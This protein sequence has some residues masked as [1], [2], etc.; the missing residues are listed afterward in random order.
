MSKQRCLQSQQCSLQGPSPAGRQARERPGSATHG[1]TADRSQG[2]CGAIA[3]GSS[4]PGHSQ[5]R[6]E[7][8]KRTRAEAKDGAGEAQVRVELQRRERQVG[9]RMP[10]RRCR[11]QKA[12]LHGGLGFRVL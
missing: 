4:D 3:S 8:A 10:R 9:C 12:L 7:L 5:N 2:L 1:D 11:G 6:E